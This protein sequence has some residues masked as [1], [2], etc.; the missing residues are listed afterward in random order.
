MRYFITPYV[1]SKDDLITLGSFFTT[2]DLDRTPDLTWLSDRI[3]EARDG[4]KIIMIGDPV[5][6]IEEEFNRLIV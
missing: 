2:N 3:T 1:S 6:V 4:D 5:E